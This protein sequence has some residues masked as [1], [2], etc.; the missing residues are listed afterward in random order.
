MV[1][2]EVADGQKWL[3]NVQ[4]LQVGISVRGSNLSRCLRC[5][6]DPRQLVSGLLSSFMLWA[7]GH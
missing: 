4:Q 1:F 6:Q 3:C 5:Y 2:G 7:A